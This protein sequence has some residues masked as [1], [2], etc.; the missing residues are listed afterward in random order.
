MI[1]VAD[2]PLFDPGTL[3]SILEEDPQCRIIIL[4]KSLGPIAAL[5]GIQYSLSVTKRYQN[6][7]NLHD[8]VPKNAKSDPESGIISNVSFL[9]HIS[10]YVWNAEVLPRL[11]S[12][13]T[14]PE[15]LEK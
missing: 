13:T 8:L 10:E 3:F 5:H 15:L 9:L 7:I 11:H 1:D 4:R 2:K 14:V 6:K 12:L